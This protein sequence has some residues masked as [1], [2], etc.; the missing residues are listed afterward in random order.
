M[1]AGGKFLRCAG[2]R[3]GFALIAVLWILAALA[4]L[5]VVGMIAG[6]VPSYGAARKPVVETLHEVF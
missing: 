2:R 1:S 4:G 5:I 6:V 3:D